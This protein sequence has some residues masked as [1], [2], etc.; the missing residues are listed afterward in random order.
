M[1]DPTGG[2]GTGGRGGIAIVGTPLLIVAIL[3]IVL[4]GGGAGATPLPAGCG[5]ATFGDITL[6]PEQLGNAQTIVTVTAQRH[7]PAYAAVVAVAASY[8]EARL[9][10]DL[11]PHDH[12]SIGLFQ[13]R[14]GLHGTGVAGNPVLSTL[15]FLDAL[16]QVPNWQSIPLTEAGADVERPA[17]AYRGR[18]AAAQPLATAVVGLL[19]PAAAAAVPAGPTTPADPPGPTQRDD[20]SPDAT[21]PAPT[22]QVGSGPA[23]GAPTNTIPCTA[24]GE[25]QVETG[26]GGV[27]IRLCA[28]GPF[29]VDTTI[30]SQV[31]AMVAAATASGLQ[32][33][34]SGYRSNARQIELRQAHCGPTDFDIYS[35]PASECSPPTAQPGKSMHEWGLALNITSSGHLIASHSDPAWQW[36]SG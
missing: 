10:N 12:D 30:A 16:V 26:P 34:G 22:C 25:G 32:L 20:N 19:W 29:V 1:D 11:V 33:G 18:Y 14:V 31:Q 21:G 8:T 7:L 3:L 5:A 24:G 36:L 27:P 13:I 4:V 35:R 6:T 15:W 17:E 2:S 9:I 23:G 28:V